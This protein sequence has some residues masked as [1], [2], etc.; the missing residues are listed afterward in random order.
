MAAE[1]GIVIGVIPGTG[2]ENEIRISAATANPPLAL[3]YPEREEDVLGFE[4]LRRQWPVSPSHTS[5][6]VCCPMQHRC[7]KVLHVHM[8]YHGKRCK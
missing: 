8:P 4:I 6:T 2:K 3:E 5:P 1:S 7:C